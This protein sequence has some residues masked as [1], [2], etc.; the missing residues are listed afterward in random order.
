MLSPVSSQ[1]STRKAKCVLVFT[2][3]SDST[4]PGPLVFIPDVVAYPPTTFRLHRTLP[5]IFRRASAERSRLDPRDQARRVSTDGSA[6]PDR[7]PPANQERVRLGT[8]LSAH[9]RG[10]RPAQGA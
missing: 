10:R 4:H 1:M 6:R 3:K 9:R 2:D 5:S 7:H 8:A